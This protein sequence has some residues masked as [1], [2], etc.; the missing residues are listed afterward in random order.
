MIKI[1][2]WQG[3]G[4]AQKPIWVLTNLSYE[5]VISIGRN[6]VKPTQVKPTAV[7]CK[8]PAVQFPR[9]QQSNVDYPSAGNDYPLGLKQVVSGM[10]DRL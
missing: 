2:A 7:A 9:F 8:V 5:L 1:E 3:H 6:L 10:V 4:I